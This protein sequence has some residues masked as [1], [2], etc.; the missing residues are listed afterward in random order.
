MLRRVRVLHRLRALRRV[1]VLR[2][3]RVLRRGGTALAVHPTGI[4]IPIV[5]LF[6]D[7]NAMFNLVDDVATRIESFATV[8]GAHA[9]PHRHF[10]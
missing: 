1:R 3:L 8:L 10:P 5:F 2:R 7:G 4:A 6:P 9:N